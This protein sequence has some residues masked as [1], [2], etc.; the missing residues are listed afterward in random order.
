MLLPRV[1]KLLAGLTTAL[2]VAGGVA[3][4]PA[5]AFAL[6]EQPESQVIAVEEVQASEELSLPEVADEVEVIS[7]ATQEESSAELE[8]ET[9]PEDNQDI[10]VAEPE[11]VEVEMEATPSN[12]GTPVAQVA[13]VGEPKSDQL[14]SPV[15][16]VEFGVSVA[17]AADVEPGDVLQVS[18]V[19]PEKVTVDGKEGNT[20]VYLMW[21]VDPEGGRAS[22]ADCE[23]SQEWLM[24]TSVYGQP[25]VS[26]LR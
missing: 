8:D 12:T 2:V 10:V 25:T 3:L 22:G 4:T 14:S 24:H 26:T 9:E 13:D 15:A 21:C 19:L 17:D 18:G 23:G 6:Q 11:Q 7:S 16:P 20:S 1:K 5:T